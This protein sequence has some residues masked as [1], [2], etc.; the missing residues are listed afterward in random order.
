[1]FLSCSPFSAG[2][3]DGENPAGQGFKGGDFFCV[4]PAAEKIL[5]GP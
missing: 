1:M 2:P 5:P 3:Q 4:A